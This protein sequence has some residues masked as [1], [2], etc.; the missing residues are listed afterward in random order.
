MSRCVPGDQKQ[1]DS[2]LSALCIQVCNKPFSSVL[3]SP[4]PSVSTQPAVWNALL[5]GISCRVL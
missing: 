4:I 5:N 1:S 3:I 2:S